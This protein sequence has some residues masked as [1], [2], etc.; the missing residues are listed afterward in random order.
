MAT[1]RILQAPG[2]TK[3]RAPSS[4][5]ATSRQA[6][7][8]PLSSSLSPAERYSAAAERLDNINILLHGLHRLHKNQ[9]R[10]STYWWPAFGQ[11]RRHVRK[12]DEEVRAVQADK[13]LDKF[14]KETEYMRRA[15][16]HA[17]DVRDQFI[18]KVYLAFSR[19]V[20]DRRH[21]QLG[22]L[23]MGVL[24]Q[25]HTSLCQI[26]GDAVTKLA[27]AEGEGQDGHEV[28]DGDKDN[29]RKTSFD[30]LPSV[31]SEN[32]DDF[33]EVI[34]RDDDSVDDKVAKM[35]AKPPTAAPKQA[36]STVGQP[37]KKR[38]LPEDDDNGGENRVV[39]IKA[40]TKASS[41]KVNDE[42]LVRPEKKKKTEDN[43]AVSR[44]EKIPETRDEEKKEKKEK[45]DKKDKEKEVKKAKKR[46]KNGDEFDDLFSGLL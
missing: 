17:H 22:L 38:P 27:I 41:T 28:E 34:A 36:V 3:A 16:A 23:L 30:S 11:L 13:A 31:K 18:P 32:D 10:V 33:G 12:L 4:S 2:P 19:L 35:N 1:K 14:V 5:T 45:R 20:A 43:V 6:S 21:A 9:H 25:V 44:P 24:A 37:T 40:K 7:Q 26:T 46:K 42:S 39:S 8:P 29:A 15:A